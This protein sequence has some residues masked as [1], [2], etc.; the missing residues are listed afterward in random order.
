[1]NYKIKFEGSEENVRNAIESIMDFE[2]VMMSPKDFTMI[3][4]RSTGKRETDR[5]T[6][7]IEDY[8]FY[9]LSERGVVSKELG[10]R[11]LQRYKEETK[12]WSDSM[13]SAFKYI[14]ENILKDYKKYGV[15]TLEDW[16]QKHWGAPRQ[17]EVRIHDNGEITLC[18]VSEL[19]RLIV[20]AVCALYGVT[21]RVC[22]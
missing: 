13:L 10:E 6:E 9:L 8:L 11:S 17:P 21:A 5:L 1:M 4:S 15:L 2:S 16:R 18:G 22:G 12:D 19:P 20:D 7:A 14:S 3:S